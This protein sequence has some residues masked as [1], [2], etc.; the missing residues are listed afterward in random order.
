MLS[1]ATCASQYG[2]SSQRSYSHKTWQRLRERKLGDKHTTSSIV[3]PSTSLLPT[4]RASLP[5]VSA[6]RRKLIRKR[7]VLD[8]SLLLAQGSGNGTGRLRRRRRRPSRRKR[9]YVRMR[10]RRSEGQRSGRRLRMRVICRR[11]LPAINEA[12]PYPAALQTNNAVSPY[13]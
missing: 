9:R 2:L 6:V 3:S 4:S 8:L 13:S 11:E 1:E 7:R 5:K 10:K 12:L